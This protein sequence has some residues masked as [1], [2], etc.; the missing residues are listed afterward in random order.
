[1][2][3][4]TLDATRAAAAPDTRRYAKTIEASKRARWEIDRDVIRGRCFDDEQD[5]MPDGLSRISRLA[6]LDAA[7]RH[8]LSRIQGRTYANMF[9]LVER[10]IGAK[11][12]ELGRRHGLGDQVAFEALVRM[13]DEE[14]KHQ[15]LFRRLETM[16][17]ERMPAG[18]RFV[19][20]PNEVAAAVLGKGDWA[21]LALTT[22]IE[23]FSLAHYRSSIAPQTGL[24][25]LWT[26]VFRFHWM[27]ESQ[28][29]VIDEMEWRAAHEAC[30]AAERDRGVDELI[31]LVAA[32]DGLVRLQA[33]ADA[34]HFLATAG[35]GLDAAQADAVRDGV[36]AAYRWQYVV[37]GA[38]EPR[39]A[40][41]LQ[42]LTTPAQIGRIQAALAP[43]V[44]HVGA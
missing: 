17:G 15:A 14:L 2:T 31:E 37:S 32:V 36:L 18:Y 25:E 19:P 38:A 26:D 22:C 11:A 12:V 28:H 43:I 24:S 5:F 33:D 35:A 6:F 3:T 13:T 44:A 29:V 7:Q 10:F 21:V 8:A 16:M 9:A 41:T 30:D 4:A 23:L 20:P 42:S 34:G 39:F 27:E 1:M 40:E